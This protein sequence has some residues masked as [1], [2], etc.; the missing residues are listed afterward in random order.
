MICKNCQASIPDKARFC[1]V[2]GAS[3]DQYSNKRGEKKKDDLIGFSAKITDPAFK[4][5]QKD[6]TSYAFIFAGILTVITTVSFFLYGALSDE[7]DNPEA[8]YIG[9][10]I[11]G[12]FIIIAL[13][14]T[15]SRKKGKTW[16]GKV[17][18]KQ[19]RLKVRKKSRGANDTSPQQYYEY[20]VF[21]KAEN[22]DEHVIAVEDDDTLF[23]YYQVGD[24]IRHHAG[25]NTYEKFDKSKDQ[26]IFC[27]AC[28]YLND[29]NDDYCVKCHCPL[30][31]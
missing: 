30:L 13:L 14:S 28:A 7:M 17:I 11:S 10:G 16:D 19:R 31:K 4:K 1:N 5:Y 9:L 24:R 26:I 12:M 29:I 3:L 27:N 18:D 15:L 25:L 6:T 2:C 8:L 21:I 22:G 20:T 23:N